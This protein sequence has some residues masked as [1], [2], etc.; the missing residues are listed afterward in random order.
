M[1]CT[2]E[3]GKVGPCHRNGI[4]LTEVVREREKPFRATVPASARSNFELVSEF[5][6]KFRQEPRPLAPDLG[7]PELKTLRLCLIL[8]EYNE[9]YD[10]LIREDIVAAADALADLEYV[11][12]GA[13]IA[14]GIDGPHVFREVH[15]SNMTKLEEGEPILRSDGKILKGRDYDPPNLRPILGL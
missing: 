2:C 10:A 1:N 7:S 11:I 15:R 14:F 6:A 9:L 4:S 12:L 13:Y 8:E 5:M 3:V